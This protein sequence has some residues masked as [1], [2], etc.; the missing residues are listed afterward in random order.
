MNH[1]ALR[2]RLDDYVDDRLDADT[3]RALEEHLAAC[4]SCREELAA[5]RRLLA[6]VRDLARSIE[7]PR[8][9]WPDID[10]RTRSGR[11]R[12]RTIW[13][14][15]YPLAAA[16]IVLMAASAA[17]TAWLVQRGAEGGSSIAS[18][19]GSIGGPPA[20]LV[21]WNESE[22]AYREAISELLQVLEVRNDEL[23]QAVVQLIERNLRIIDRAIEESR[24]ALAADPTNRAIM[25]ALSARY[26]AKIETLQRL[27]RLTAEL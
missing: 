5:L 10:R 8:D 27:S 7:P 20:V 4:A 15:R 2:A 9:L 11:W 23:D 26:Q 3:R 22:R 6:E 25:E 12:T 17:V 18:G 16:V 14:L 19:R 1:E 24:A 21:G 13:S